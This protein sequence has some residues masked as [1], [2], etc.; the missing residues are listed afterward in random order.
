MLLTIDIN[1]AQEGE[2]AIGEIVDIPGVEEIDQEQKNSW[3]VTIEDELAED[4]LEDIQGVLQGFTYEAYDREDG[5]VLARD[6][7]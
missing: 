5:K 2:K 1:P 6:I 7:Q 3:T 4:I